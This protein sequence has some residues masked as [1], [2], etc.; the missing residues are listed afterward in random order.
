[1]NKTI[2]VLALSLA[3]CGDPSDITSDASDITSSEGAEGLSQ[4]ARLVEQAV[5]LAQARIDGETC[6]REAYVGAILVLLDTALG[7]EPE[8]EASVAA[9]EA[10]RATVGNTLGFQFMNGAIRP[11]AG[12]LVGFEAALASG[13]VVYGPAEGI[14][15]NTHVITFRPSGEA[16]L[17]TRSFNDEGDLVET[18]SALTYTVDDQRGSITMQSESGEATAYQLRLEDGVDKITL[19]AP[20]NSLDEAGKQV[21]WG[22]PDECSA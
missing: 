17:I 15:G 21:L 4:G 22:A 5:A 19:V 12:R 16:E 10:L 20:N 18:E 9:N 2:L 8:L 1:M 11:E 14:I 6:E 3:A 7:L 13:V